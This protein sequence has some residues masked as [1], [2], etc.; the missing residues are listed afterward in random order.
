MFDVASICVILICNCKFNI[1][2]ENELLIF[3]GLDL[4]RRD[5]LALP[6]PD[7]HQLGPG[8]DD[9]RHKLLRFEYKNKKKRNIKEEENIRGKA[10]R[11]RA[12]SK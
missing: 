1:F 7:R 5:R 11:A 3:F 8:R 10:K 2:F 6:E 9:V 12:M 4:G